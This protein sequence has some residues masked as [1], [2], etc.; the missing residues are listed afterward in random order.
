MALLLNGHDTS[1]TFASD[2]SPGIECDLISFTPWGFTVAT[3]EQ[4]TMS[5]AKYKT[6]SASPLIDV[7]PATAVFAYSTD[8]IAKI[9]AFQNTS[10]LVTVTMPDN[11]TEAVNAFVSSMTRSELT[12]EGRPTLT[13]EIM[14][15]MLSSGT[16][17]APAFA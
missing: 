17:T 5:N 8:D 10:Q 1:I 11:G 14:P 15:T 2:S 3:I 6:K 16:E 9:L 13:M 12:S 4:T 7:T